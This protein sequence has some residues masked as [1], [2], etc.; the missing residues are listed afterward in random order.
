M[1]ARPGRRVGGFLSR[2]RSGPFSDK[3]GFGRVRGVLQGI[4]QRIGLPVL[5]CS[6]FAAN[7]DHRP[8]KTIQ[9]RL[10]FALGR[11]DHERS[12]YGKGDRRSV[13]A[14]IHQPLRYIVDLDARALF[15]GAQ[16]QDTFVG[17][18]SPRSL[19]QDRIIRIE[20]F[21]DIVG[22]EYRIATRLAER[23]RAHQVQVS[24]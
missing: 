22:V 8:A 20:P 7:R 9:L 14:V 13:K 4:V 1:L 15:Q 18:E 16:V 24:P 5:Y 2:I 6:D 12:R 23:F 21:G 11:L 3:K 10:G 19:I 17:D